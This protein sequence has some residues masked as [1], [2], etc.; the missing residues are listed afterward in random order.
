MSFSKFSP[1]AKMVIAFITTAGMGGGVFAAIVYFGPIWLT[2]WAPAQPIKFSHKL[3]AGTNKIS[4]EYCHS[5]ARR[6][7]MASIPSADRCVYCHDYIKADAPEIVKVM[8]H[9]NG[10]K[11]IEWVKV[12]DLPDHVWFNHKRHIAKDVPCQKCHGPVETMDV[13]SRTNEFS[14]GFCLA[15]H[16]ENE[17]PTDC[18]TC[19]T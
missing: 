7:E 6:S 15:C 8:D 16:Q 9:Y 3:H 4:C 12:F 5:Y 1:I 19:H 18:W 2:T 10:D 17:A 13:V 14:M 11:P